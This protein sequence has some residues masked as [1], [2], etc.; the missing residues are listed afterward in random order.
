M[1]FCELRDEQL[2]SVCVQQLQSG[3]SMMSSTP[4]RSRKTRHTAH[5]QVR[6]NFL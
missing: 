6:V 3:K 5:T 2:M 4:E 1:N